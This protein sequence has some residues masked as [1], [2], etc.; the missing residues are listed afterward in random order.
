MTSPK[1]PMGPED[2]PQQLL[3]AVKELPLKPEGIEFIHLDFE[4]KHN[5]RGIP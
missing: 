5:L 4:A 3:H 1:I 2:L